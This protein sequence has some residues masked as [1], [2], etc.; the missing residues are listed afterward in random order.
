[1]AAITKDVT[2]LHRLQKSTE[3][4]PVLLS[5]GEQVRILRE[6]ERHYLIKTADGKV[7]N[8]LKEYVDPAG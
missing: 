8:I 4:M 3:S 1:M 5:S 7:F 2:L 6:W